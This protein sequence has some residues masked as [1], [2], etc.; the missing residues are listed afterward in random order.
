MHSTRTAKNI[1]LK[2]RRYDIGSRKSE[3]HKTFEGLSIEFLSVIC[4]FENNSVSI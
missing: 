3:N 4:H 1:L 2:S